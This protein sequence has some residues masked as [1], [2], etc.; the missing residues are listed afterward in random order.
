VIRSQAAPA[1]WKTFLAV[2]GPGLVVTFA[3]TDVGSVITAA[4]SGTQWGYRLLLQP[5]LVP[6]LHIVQELT[7]RLAIFTGTGHGAPALRRLRL[8]R[9]RGPIADDRAR[10]L[11]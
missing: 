3:D 9:H 11:R 6:V 2:P 8:G 5:L 7:V 4:Q 10:C 1:A